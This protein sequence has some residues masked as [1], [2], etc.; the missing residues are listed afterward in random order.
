VAQYAG[1]DLVCYFAEAPAELVARQAA[2][3]EPL[4]ARAEAELGLRFE[5]CAGIVHRE[6]PAATL[7]AVR[8]LA[9]AESDFGLAGLA[10]GTSLFGSAVLG[11][12]LRRGWLSGEAAYDLS[13]VDEA[14]QERSGASTPR[15]PSARNALRGEAA[16][17][18]RWFR[19]LDA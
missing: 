8:A 4:L 15:P 17:L 19:G 6:Q 7:A 16:V 9:L 14:F 13:R 10:F 18:D 5:R 1:S 12:A 11:L 3:W 2:A